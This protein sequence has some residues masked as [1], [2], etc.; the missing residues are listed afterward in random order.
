MLIYYSTVCELYT[1]LC[2]RIISIES[3]AKVLSPLLE[4]RAREREGFLK[5]SVYIYS[6]PQPSP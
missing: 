2:R 5:P 1:S 4:E 6:P 3:S